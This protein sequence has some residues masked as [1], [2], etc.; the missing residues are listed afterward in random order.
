MQVAPSTRAS[1]PSFMLGIVP[2][3]CLRILLFEQAFL[4]RLGRAPPGA[5]L[6]HC[7]Y[8]QLRYRLPWQENP[9]GVGTGI[10]RNEEQPLPL[11]QGEIVLSQPL[12]Q[13]VILQPRA[14]PQALAPGTGDKR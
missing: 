7:Q 12:D 5:G 6:D 14:H 11:D 2:D 1:S 10:G 3:S 8:L 13:I 4:P 9:L